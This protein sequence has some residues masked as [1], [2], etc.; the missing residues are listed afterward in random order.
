MAVK[1]EIVLG[2]DGKVTV[3]GPLTNKII[4]FGMLTVAQQVIE[5]YVPQPKSLIEVPEFEAPADIR[6]FRGPRSITDD[7]GR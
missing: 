3:N 4:C 6:T 2:D 7:D 1:I 5:A